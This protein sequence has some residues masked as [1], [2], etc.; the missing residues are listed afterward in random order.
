M[1]LRPEALSGARYLV[2]ADQ[3]NADGRHV[4]PFNAAFPVDV[5]QHTLSGA[6]P[7][8]MNQHDYFELV[9]LI[10]GKLVWQI[11]DSF[12][13]ETEGDLFVM[14]SPRFHRLTEQSDAEIEVRSLF[15]DRN[16]LASAAGSDSAYLD[17]LFTRSSN[18][19]HLVPRD[20]GL[21]RKVDD[22]MKEIARELPASS[23]RARLC[24]RTYIK[25][26]LVLLMDHVATLGPRQSTAQRR[27]KSLDRLKPL[28][29][30]IERGYASRISTEDAADVVNMSLSTFRRTF[31]HLTG[32][33]FV[34]YLNTFRIAKAQK[35]LAS[36]EMPI[37]EVCLEVGFCD[38]SYFGMIFR[39]FTQMTP[40]HYRQQILDLLERQPKPIPGLVPARA[41]QLTFNSVHDGKPILSS[42]FDSIQL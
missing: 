25:M 15:F 22:L 13:T 12:L 29:D 30:I 26:I 23:D 41:T 32:Q 24:V 27:E 37:S 38:Q 40:R 14:T 11:Q 18:Q 17:Y 33:S 36:S 7:F 8:R 28:F 42:G 9:F 3:V 39:R 16:L 2:T 31:M 5:L 35:L 4:W 10:S 34:Q 20:T 19:Q 21:P 6:K 1:S